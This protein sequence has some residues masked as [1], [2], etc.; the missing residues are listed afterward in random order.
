MDSSW[1]SYIS[2]SQALK[3]ASSLVLGPSSAGYQAWLWKE[4]SHCLVEKLYLLIMLPMSC[5]FLSWGGKVLE[6]YHFW[7][8]GC[9]WQSL[10]TTLNH[11]LGST[12]NIGTERMVWLSSN[13]YYAWH[14]WLQQRP[15]AILGWDYGLARLEL[16]NLG[17]VTC[18]CLV[19]Q[20]LTVESFLGESTLM[21][22]SSSDKGT[23]C[24]WSSHHLCS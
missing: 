19:S 22:Q 12:L 7:V 15:L 16:G 6:P 17:T 24:Q 3:K 10:R 4:K 20:R 14:P 5:H 11:L 1:V 2:I 13:C 18:D 9:H 23:Q 8:C 21:Q